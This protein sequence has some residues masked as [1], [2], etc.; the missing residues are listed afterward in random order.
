M[1]VVSRLI[2]EDYANNLSGRGLNSAGATQLRLPLMSFQ[3]RGICVVLTALENGFLLFFSAMD[4]RE[5]RS[6]KLSILDTHLH[7]KCQ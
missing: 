7:K 2:K 5:V 3:R 1:P 4:E 6:I